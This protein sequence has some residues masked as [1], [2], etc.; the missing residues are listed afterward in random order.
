MD[1]LFSIS[2]QDE[3]KEDGLKDELLLINNKIKVGR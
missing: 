3:R 2:R 1:H